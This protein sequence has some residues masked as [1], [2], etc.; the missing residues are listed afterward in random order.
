MCRKSDP[1]LVCPPLPCV[2]LSLTN[3]QTLRL[4]HSAEGAAP[5][6]EGFH[7]QGPRFRG[8]PEQ[9]VPVRHGGQRLR[10]HVVRANMPTAV[11]YE[12][13]VAGLI[14]CCSGRTN[15]GALFLLSMFVLLITAALSSA[16]AGHIRANLPPSIRFFLLLNKVSLLHSS[17]SMSCDPSTTAVSLCQD[18]LLQYVPTEVR[19]AH[20]G[21]TIAVGCYPNLPELVWS[22]CF[23]RLPELTWPPAVIQPPWLMCCRRFLSI[24]P[25]VD[26]ATVTTVPISRLVYL[27]IADI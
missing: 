27:A 9:S 21:H 17:H 4:H 16:P 18:S 13:N 24:S 5:T 20:P 14:L 23:V 25:W 10:R 2:T 19:V 6:L 8:R 7:A 15:E 26:L 11:R 1:A 22:G 12:R 3:R